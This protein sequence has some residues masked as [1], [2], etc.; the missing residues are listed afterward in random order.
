MSVD[1][2][3]D[4]SLSGESGISDG[5]G[6][7]V[8]I[9]LPLVH[10]VDL[11]SLVGND[12]EEAA[13]LGGGKTIRNDVES[14]SHEGNI[15]PPC[16]VGHSESNLL[17]LSNSDD[18]VKSVEVEALSTS[19][20]CGGTDASCAFGFAGLALFVDVLIEAVSA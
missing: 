13:L 1:G 17:E 15:I 11:V 9:H 10:E 20:A 7:G 14:N 2:Q 12:K 3:E 6:E 18:A 16:N 19:A 8:G 5:D 4:C